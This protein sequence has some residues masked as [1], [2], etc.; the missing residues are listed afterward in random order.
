M[1][2]ADFVSREFK[3]HGIV[4]DVIATAP[5]NLLIV[6]YVFHFEFHI[7][8]PVALRQEIFETRSRT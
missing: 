7:A 6:R 5:A 2:A 8:I 3:E 1:I 4:P